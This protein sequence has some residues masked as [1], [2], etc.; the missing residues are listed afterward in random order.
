[1]SLASELRA[2]GALFVHD[3]RD[4]AIAFRSKPLEPKD[5]KRLGTRFG[6]GFAIS[7][8]VGAIGLAFGDRVA[9][10]SWRF[11]RSCPRASR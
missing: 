2:R 6:F 5:V 10:C 3:S 11:P 9:G 7:V 4:E 8:I 1:M